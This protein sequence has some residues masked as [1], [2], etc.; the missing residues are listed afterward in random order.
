MWKKISIFLH[1]VLKVYSVVHIYGKV[2]GDDFHQ[3][4]VK[5]E[6]P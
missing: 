3:K 2:L 4:L 1:L 5:C 6:N